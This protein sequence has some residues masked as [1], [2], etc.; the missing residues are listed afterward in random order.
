MPSLLLV[1][2]GQAA[3]GAAEY[4]VLSELGRRQA[5]ALGARLARL[6]PVACL[7]HGRLA[8]Q[9]DTAAVLAEAVDVRARVEEPRLDEY[10]HEA[11]LAGA[12]RAGAL[13]DGLARL[14]EPGVDRN[15]VYQDLLELALRRWVARGADED[16]GEAWPAFVDRAAAAASDLLAALEPSETGVAVTSGGV[17][18]AVC[19]RALGLDGEG[20]LRLNLVLANASL[21]RLVRGRRGTTLVTVNDHGHLEIPGAGLLTYR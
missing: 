1:R 14:Q 9:R 13:G 2:H 3:F 8:R 12:D 11:L 21:T 4:D 17:V 18:A 7:A 20:W 5:A 19:A 16:D 10:G 15:R 6:G